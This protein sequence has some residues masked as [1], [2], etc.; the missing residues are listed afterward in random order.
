M[1]FSSTFHHFWGFGRKNSIDLHFGDSILSSPQW[2]LSRLDLLYTWWSLASYLEMY[3]LHHQSFH[4]VSIVDSSLPTLSSTIISI[5][6][7]RII[8][9][10]GNEC[11]KNTSEFFFQIPSKIPSME[12]EIMKNAYFL[13]HMWGIVDVKYSLWGFESCKISNFSDL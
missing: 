3:L 12:L 6:E 9:I 10:M 8:Q 1:L 2:S 5:W 11:V 4:V 7:K 13:T